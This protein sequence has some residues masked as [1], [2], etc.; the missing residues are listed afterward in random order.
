[1]TRYLLSTG[2][3]TTRIERYILD[4]FKLNIQIY[5]NDIP[6]SDIGF[7]FILGDTKK[8]QILTEFGNRVSSLVNKI[9]S[10]FDNKIYKINIESIELI[11][12]TR[13][14]VTISVG[15]YSDSVSLNLYE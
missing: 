10:R 7:D 3:S 2:Q 11:D 4:L 5:P 9:Q 8:D 15:D 1:M 6:G 12:E 13:I 14:R